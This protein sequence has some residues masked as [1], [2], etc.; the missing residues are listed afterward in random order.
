M[1][2]KSTYIRQVALITLLAQ[3]GSFVPARSATI[4]VADRIFARVGASDELSRGQSTFMVE[5]TETARIL[6]TATPRSLVILDEIGRGTSTYDG[7]SLAWSVVEY[8]HEHVGCRTLFA[9]HYHEL[10]D[11]ARSLSTVKN[12]NVAVRE[13]DDEVVF[14]HKI[15]EGA[16]DKSYG[17]HVAR[18]AG[19]PREVLQRAKE[20][21][22]QLEDGH[23]DGEGRSRI[24]K[25]RPRRPAELQMTLFGPAEHP[26]LDELRQLDLNQTTPLRALELLGQWQATLRKL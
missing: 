24:A 6:N 22:A 19:V 21:L 18:L 15:I 26:L 23:L 13:W 20:I 25:R 1:A 11:L 14:L 2:G 7:V 5:M 8:L 16:A 4:G 12:L 9:T 10:T 3:L 17:I